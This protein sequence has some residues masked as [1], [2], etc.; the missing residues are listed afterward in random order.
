MLSSD[1]GSSQPQPQPQRQRQRRCTVEQASTESSIYSEFSEVDTSNI[2]CSPQLT[3]PLPSLNLDYPITEKNAKEEEEKDE[4]DVIA[5]VDISMDI[6]DKSMEEMKESI[7]NSLSVWIGEMK[8]D[9]LNSVNFKIE[10]LVASMEQ[11]K[12]EAAD[13][14]TTNGPTAEKDLGTSDGDERSKGDL[15][16]SID[17]A[18]Q[19]IQEVVEENKLLMKRCK[20]LEGRVTRAEKIITDLKE[21]QLQQEA[22]GMKDKLNFFNI[23]EEKGENCRAALQKFMNTELGL[24]QDVVKQIE[25][26][27]VHRVGRP[28]P[29]HDNRK[30]VL[31]AQ[32]KT[33]QGRDAVMK[34]VRNLN[35]DKITREKKFGVSDMLPRELAERRKQLLPLYRTAKQNKSKVKWIK[36][37]LSIDGDLKSIKRDHVIDVHQDCVEK[38]LEIEANIRH[39]QPE[40]YRNCT[41]QGHSSS[42]KSQDEVIPTLNA[43]HMDSRTSRASHTIYAYRIRDNNGSLIEH[44]ED[45][46]DYGTGTKLLGLLRETNEVNK[47]ICVSRWDNGQ[48]IGQSRFELAIKVARSS[49]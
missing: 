34:S 35:R 36:D 12:C 46:G 37:R 33:S 26:V 1:S 48:F 5:G 27:D 21:S 20:I 45:D 25:L 41:F 9:V 38:T 44:Y 16:E 19:S 18:H 10:E 29:R 13:S 40:S 15:L 42:I 28:R 4:N 8:M 6:M 23:P 49:L 24:T 47:M 39:S 32:F 7:K 11:F 31:I 14:I 17:F 3:T 2:N 43:I 30:R 22:D